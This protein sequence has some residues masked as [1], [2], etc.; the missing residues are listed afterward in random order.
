RAIG[1]WL[2]GRALHQRHGEAECDQHGQHRP[3][4][5]VNRAVPARHRSTLSHRTSTYGHSAAAPGRIKTRAPRLTGAGCTRVTP[6]LAKA[7]AVAMP[8]TAYSASALSRTATTRC[9]R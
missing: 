8:I 3:E 7:S 1:G 4:Q 5:T 6:Q 9:I 2:G